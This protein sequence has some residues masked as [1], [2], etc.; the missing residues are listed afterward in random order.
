M[1]GLARQ[2]A[3]CPICPCSATSPWKCVC[4]AYGA[5]PRTACREKCPPASCQPMFLVSQKAETLVQ[6]IS[7]ESRQR[8]AGSRTLQLAHPV[9][10]QSA[11]SG[12]GGTAHSPGLRAPQSAHTL[13]PGT[14]L[15]SSCSARSLR[16]CWRL[17]RTE[18]MMYCRRDAARAS[19][20]QRTERNPGSA[21]GGSKREC[22]V[23]RG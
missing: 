6:D 15:M 13:F 8:K 22:V 11:G 21:A 1:R 4:P 20:M 23:C 16:A 17:F 2:P 7:H 19:W 5:A 12:S 10:C 14:V 9:H 3:H 18:A